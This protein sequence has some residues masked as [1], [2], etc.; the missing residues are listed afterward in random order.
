[1]RKFFEFISIFFLIL[2]VLVSGFS[3]GEDFDLVPSF[4]ESTDKYFVVEFSDLIYQE[5]KDSLENIGVFFISYVGDNSFL[6]KFDKNIVDEVSDFSFIKSVERFKKNK[7]SNNEKIE[8]TKEIQNFRV[9][10]F[11]VLSP[12][13]FKVH[14]FDKSVSSLFEN[15]VLS[16]GGEI[17]SS[18]NGRLLI[19]IDKSKVSFLEEYEQVN[20]IYSYSYPQIQNVNSKST[21]NV[22][23]YFN[24][25]N[26]FGEGQIVAVADTGLDIGVH[27]SSFHADFLNKSVEI[28]ELVGSDGASDLDSGHGTHV[29]GSVLGN[30]VLSG[31][32]LENNNYVGSNSGMA[33]KSD[34]YFQA[35]EYW[36]G[37][38]FGLGVP[39]NL[40]TG[41]FEPAYVF[42]AQIHSNSWGDPTSLG[43]YSSESVDV[44][45]FTWNNK[46][47][48]ILFAAGNCGTGGNNCEYSGANSVLPPGTSKNAITVGASSV[49]LSIASFSSK[50][51]TDDG[52]IKPDVV[53]PGS[54]I[55]S[56]KSHV[57]GG[58]GDYSVKSGTSMAT[59]TT[60]GIVSLLREYLIK[61]K[62]ISSPTSA[63][64]KAML[65]N[66]AKDI[67]GTMPD[68]NQGWGF[69]DLNRTIFE[70][71]K[72]SLELFEI[73]SGLSTSQEY[74]YNF[75]INKSSLE[76][77]VSLVWTD[78][79][80]SVGAGNKL[81]N[82][83][84]LVL[85]SPDGTEYFG[86]DFSYPFNDSVDLLNNVEGIRIKLSDSGNYSLKIKGSNVPNGPQPFSYVISTNSLFEDVSIN[87]DNPINLSNLDNPIVGFNVSSS[88]NSDSAWISFDNGITNYSMNKVNLTYFNYSYDF[89]TFGNYSAIVFMNDSI[90]GKIFSSDKV[91]FTVNE[92]RI[93]FVSPVFDSVVTNYD[94]WYNFSLNFS[95]NISEVFYFNG[96]NY[97]DLSSS[98]S[99][100]WLNISLNLTDVVNQSI[101][102]NVTDIYGIKSSKVINFTF[103]LLPK[104]VIYSPLNNT[105]VNV[106]K[107]NFFINASFNKNVSSLIYNVGSKKIDITDLVVNNKLVT[108]LTIF[109]YTSQVISFNF[110]DD[111]GIFDI[112]ELFVNFSLNLGGNATDFDNDGVSDLVDNV[113]GDESNVDSSFSNLNISINLSSNLSKVFDEVLNV[114]FSNN[115]DKLV[116][117]SYNF[118]NLSIDFTKVIIKSEVKSNKSKFFVSGLELESGN[119]KT[120]YLDLYGNISK[121]HSLCLKDLEVGS[122]DEISDL[123]DGDNETFVDVIPKVV[124]GYNVSYTDLSNSTVKISGL[125]HSGVSQMCTEDWSYGS[126]GTCSSSSQ[127]RVAVDLNSC[128][129]S[130]TR[131]SLVQSCSSSSS[132]SSGGGGGG[133]SSSS[134]SEDEFG[135]VKDE[136]NKFNYKVDGDSISSSSKFSRKEDVLILDGSLK[137][138]EFGY[139]FSD[140][141]LD[142]SDIEI[143]YDFTD[144]S[145]IILKGFSSLGLDKTVYL[146]NNLDLDYV[147]VKNTEISS[148]SSF[149]KNCLGSNEYYFK[150]DNKLYSGFYCSL[151][152]GYYKISGLKSSAVIEAD[153]FM[154]SSNEED[155][156]D[157]EE[158]VEIVETENDDIEVVKKVKTE[159]DDLKIKNFKTMSDEIT[160]KVKGEDLKVEDI[161]LTNQEILNESYESEVVEEDSR[162]MIYVL[163]GVFVLAFVVFVRIIVVRKNYL[164]SEE[165]RAN[166]RIFKK[167][168]ADSIKIGKSRTIIKNELYN[169]NKKEFYTMIDEVIEKEFSTNKEK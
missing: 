61:N 66:G 74:E 96:T 41:M 158:I 42:G 144:R 31:A 1:M 77:R 148:I 99:D 111:L 103:N 124:N 81:V 4:V 102:F 73:S 152:S 63:L 136:D 153:S 24:E 71:N 49:D 56:T 146:K 106:S 51:P 90:N 107:L 165:S 141:E 139:D 57:N 121:A 131:E 23:N 113:V 33:P 69:V 112:Y 27:N 94:L 142:L 117:F 22:Y 85:I 29:A 40:A 109:N 119:T 163:A 60:A 110:T 98:L 44:D 104:L 75:T 34:L 157:V 65:I 154:V 83:L 87:L 115:S 168:V 20:F 89:S 162:V 159:N 2:I 135:L 149:S 140:E 114:S 5:D 123:C 151:S 14:L 164:N 105:V 125:S 11:N 3:K 86:N 25:F 78:Y 150:C 101:L 64:V 38:D 53:A 16:L 133:G 58:S 120:I 166:H 97:V 93:N 37:S 128:G 12:E 10:N 160:D 28:I 108:N 55:T 116:E 17:I 54:G 59:P 70:D 35:L 52:R 15:E 18:D 88:N 80:S 47:M 43:D 8:K 9:S 21:T 169:C 122:L 6:T 134:T 50:G 127:S 137:L 147:C 95:K 100:N 26:L 48:I 130:Y 45:T 82:N 67:T 92:P 79:P 76:F 39:N 138:V 36:T 84:D 167:Y 91:Y 129:T 72:N 156:E 132:G 7:D 68:M 13:L 62:S 32:D 46:D 126:W 161:N 30:G 145:S 155:V 118:S 143:K 19:L